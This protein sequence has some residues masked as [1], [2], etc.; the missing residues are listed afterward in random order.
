MRWHHVEYIRGD[1]VEFELD[2]ISLHADRFL[3]AAV[4][5]D[6]FVQVLPG[7]LEER[8]FG[9]DVRIGIEQQDLRAWLVLL[10]IAGDLACPLV[11]S[12]RAAIGRR[13]HGEHVYAAV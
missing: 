4:F 2:G 9:S 8:A 1:A 13:R 5:E 11:R 10:E 3:P 7:S 6:A 12:G